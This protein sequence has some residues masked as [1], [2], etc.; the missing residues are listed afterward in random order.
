MPEEYKSRRIETSPQLNH[1][2][3]CWIPQADV[4]WH[5]QG[6]ERRQ[7]LAGPADRFKIIDE[8]ETYAVEMAMAWIDAELVDDLTP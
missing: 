1:D 2:T 4:S 6:Q 3:D 8:A 5:E 7:L